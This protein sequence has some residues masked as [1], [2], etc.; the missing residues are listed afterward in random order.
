MEKFICTTAEIAE[1]LENTVKDGGCVPLA[2]TGSSMM[3]FLKEGRDVVWLRKCTEADF[4]RGKI[5]LFRRDNGAFILH[6]IREIL[7]DN[8]LL[9]NGDA[10]YWCETINKSQVIAVVSEIERDG[11]KK[12]CSRNFLWHILKPLRPYIF[13]IQR[14]IKKIS[15]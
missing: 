8:K 9:M 1:T 4:E 2:V 7:P 11:K 13:R 5:L 15:E 3:P 6:R 12:P 14:K 10:Q